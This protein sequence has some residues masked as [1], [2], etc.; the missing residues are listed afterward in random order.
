MC[1]HTYVYVITA[2][3]QKTTV[4]IARF[5]SPRPDAQE[6]PVEADKKQVV[7]KGL[8]KD[9]QEEKQDKNQQQKSQQPQQQ[10]T[11]KQP[12]DIPTTTKTV[13]KQGK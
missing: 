1:C 10:V 4:L 13:I 12:T 5:K 6:P 9:Q 7:N 8:L 2:I 3:Y 11:V